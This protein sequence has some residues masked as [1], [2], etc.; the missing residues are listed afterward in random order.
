MT[1]EPAVDDDELVEV[2]LL[3][4]P[5]R[6]GRRASEHYEEVFRELALLADTQ[7]P[8]PDSLPSRM[9]AL[10]GDLGRRYPRQQAHEE[11]RDAALRAGET[12]RHM[13]IRVG[14]SMVEGT[15][16]LD[17]LLDETDD[18]C[19]AGTLLTLGPPQGVVAFRRWYLEQ[20][21]TQ[22]QGGVCAPWTGDLG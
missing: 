11:E 3:R 17:A 2:H 16:A 4:Y 9:L 14:A 5:L 12:S 8:A 10:V 21:T 18:L 19:R 6:V 13:V 15:K 20:C 7:P 1:P 22:L